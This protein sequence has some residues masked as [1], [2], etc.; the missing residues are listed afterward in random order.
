MMTIQILD[1]T[2]YYKSCISFVTL[3]DATQQLRQELQ[4]HTES[5]TSTDWERIFTEIQR[6]SNCV[7][8]SDTRQWHLAISRRSN[9]RRLP[10]VRHVSRLRSQR[11]A[12]C[13]ASEPA[14][15]RA[16]TCRP[17]AARTGRCRPSSE[18][19][20]RELHRRQ[21]RQGSTNSSDPPETDPHLT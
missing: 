12:P 4:L 14:S 19:T 8:L 6:H 18:P 16:R 5:S 9:S 13:A 21:S 2:Y 10:A 20:A 3:E 7:K 15:I 1:T 11:F 17:D